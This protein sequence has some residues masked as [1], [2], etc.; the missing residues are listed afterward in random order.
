VKTKAD[1]ELEAYERQLVEVDG[2][3]C[4]PQE[5]G[6][7]RHYIDLG[8]L[9]GGVE[10]TPSAVGKKILLFLPALY[11]FI[12]SVQLL[13]A[14]ASAIGPS[15]QGEFPFA[16]G[17]STLGFG[18]LAAYV[19]LSGSPVAATAIALFGAGTL[20]VLQTFTM[21]A[22]SR[23]GA[24]FIVLVT[25]LL[26]AVR[27]KAIK[28]RND[29]IGVGIQAMTLTAFVYIPG[30]L[31]GYLVLRNGWLDGV[32]LHASGGLEA[33]LS[34]AWGPI[35]DRLEGVL[36]GWALFLAGIGAILV[37]FNLID[38]VL[39]EVSSDGTASKHTQWLTHPW[40]MFLLG[41]IVATLTLSVSV[42]LTILVPLASR[43]LVKRDQALPYIMGANIMTLVDTLVV[44]ML[45]PTPVAAHI[46]LALGIGVAI[47]SIVILAFLYQPV[48]RNVLAF[49]DWLVA[50]RPRLWGFV[51]FL[52]A[53][54]IMALATGFVWNA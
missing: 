8:P 44:A 37:S 40:T 53:I 31:I 9:F 19:V 18:W 50:S 5:A 17:I 26:Y 12:L 54:P 46:V 15:I 51:G 43:G 21:L 30:M 11:L 4:I 34:V 20:T 16:N 32:D 2:E 49:D 6:E 36:P 1:K 3:F 38:R 42:A 25:G 48:K 14:G 10:K 13:K 33:A 39:P 29:S 35:V 47:V 7:A 23:L 41:C 22:G 24:S 28:N 52:F 27:G 45:L